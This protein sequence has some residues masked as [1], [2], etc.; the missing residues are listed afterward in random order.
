[1]RPIVK[2][3]IFLPLREWMDKG[4][5]ELGQHSAARRPERPRPYT[6]GV[7]VSI[8]FENQTSV[9]DFQPEF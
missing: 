3:I 8:M 5:G 4:C 2:K 6:V 7:I 9:S 1:M